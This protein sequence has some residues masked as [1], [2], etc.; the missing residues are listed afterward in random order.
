MNQENM[1]IEIDTSGYK[2]INGDM[3]EDQLRH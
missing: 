2:I 3:T 1:T